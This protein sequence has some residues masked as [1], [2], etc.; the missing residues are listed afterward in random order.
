MTD[1]EESKQTED[2]VSGEGCPV[3]VPKLRLG[4]ANFSRKEI[5]EFFDNMSDYEKEMLPLPLDYCKARGIST[6]NQVS[7]K[8]LMKA[9]QMCQSRLEQYEEREELKKKMERTGSG[10]KKASLKK[11]MKKLS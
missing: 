2:I 7:M 9:P 11:K 10:K 5:W 3:T 6:A 4:N 1:I 8:E